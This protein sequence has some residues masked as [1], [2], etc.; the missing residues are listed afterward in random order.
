[1]IWPQFGFLK[2]EQFLSQRNGFFDP[3]GFRVQ[4]SQ[5]FHRIEPVGAIRPRF[6]FHKFERFFS[7]R[8]GF[9]DPPGGF[10]P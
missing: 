8:N 9:V 2:F 7:Q 5:F 1:M 4:Q 6:G 3:A 10:I